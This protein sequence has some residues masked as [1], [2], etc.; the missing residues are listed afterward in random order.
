M[1]PVTSCFPRPFL[2]IAAP[3]RVS[4]TISDQTVQ[5]KNW[6]GGRERLSPLFPLLR[7]YFTQPSSEAKKGAVERGAPLRRKDAPWPCETPPA[8]DGTVV[9]HIK[10]SGCHDRQDC[11]HAHTPTDKCQSETV[12]MTSQYWAVVV[13]SSRSSEPLTPFKPLLRKPLELCIQSSPVLPG[14]ASSVVFARARPKCSVDV[15]GASLGKI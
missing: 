15:P 11:S 8:E 2:P 10:H 12:K 9:R 5:P 4:Q 13:A 7:L 14:M 1:A 3:H 6:G